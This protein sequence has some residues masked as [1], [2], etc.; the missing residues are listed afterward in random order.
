MATNLSRQLTR[1]KTLQKDEPRIPKKAVASF[2][3]DI[4]EAAHIDV[5]T[6]YSLAQS[7]INDISS[8]TPQITKFIETLFSPSSKTFNR[9]TQTSDELKQVDNDLAEILFIL[10]PQFL[11]PS[12]HRILEYLIRVYDIHIYQRENIIEGLLPY[13]ESPLFVRFAQLLNLESHP[14]YSFLDPRVRKGN[15]LQRDLLIAEIAKSSKLLERIC[16]YSLLAISKLTANRQYYSSFISILVI[17]LS[18]NKDLKNNLKPEHMRILLKYVAD[19][20]KNEKHLESWIDSIHSIVLT[21][22]TSQ[23]LNIEY[24]HALLSDLVK[25]SIPE[26]YQ[27]MQ[28]KTIACAIQNNISITQLRKEVIVK[29]LSRNPEIVAKDH[30]RYIKVI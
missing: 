14:I 3:F 23:K 28:W 13:I 5:G 18:D 22:C 6:L 10:C 17:E 15:L 9:F 27:S 2:L 7:G 12:C 20:L 26:S 16:S 1:L 30:E 29:L 21:L 25:S 4:Q 24:I 11:H 8:L 19:V